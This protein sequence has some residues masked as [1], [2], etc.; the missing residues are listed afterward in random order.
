MAYKLN[1]R[2][3]LYSSSIYIS[4]FCKSIMIYWNSANNSTIDFSSTIKKKNKI[5][6]SDTICE[7]MNLSYMMIHTWPKSHMQSPPSRLPLIL[8]IWGTRW[9]N[10]RYY[11]PSRS[12]LFLLSLHASIYIPSML[13]HTFDELV[14]L[15]SSSSTIWSHCFWKTSWCTI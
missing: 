1:K 11:P 10:F 12:S 8:N 3:V 9:W 7:P 2:R 6:I 5:I 15:A 13:L 4:I 14:L